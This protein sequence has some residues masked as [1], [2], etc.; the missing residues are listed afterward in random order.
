MGLKDHFVSLFRFIERSSKKLAGQNQLPLEAL[1]GTLLPMLKEFEQTSKQFV[2]TVQSYSIKSLL[3]KEQ[4]DLFNKLE[5]A[6]KSVLKQFEEYGYVTKN[7]YDFFH[8][9]RS[10]RYINKFS[11]NQKIRR[12]LQKDRMSIGPERAFPPLE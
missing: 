6:L 10:T 1:E 4:K 11:S 9:E 5:I 7:I 2:F 8:K 3:T 12:S